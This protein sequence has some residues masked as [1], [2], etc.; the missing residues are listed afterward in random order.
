[1][2]DR[3]NR[4]RCCLVCGQIK[5]VQSFSSA[6]CEN[7]EEILQLR[8]SMDRILECTSAC[9]QGT[10][11]IIDSQASWL[12]KWQRS[13]G[14]VAGVYAVSVT[15]DLPEEIESIVADRGITPRC[16]Q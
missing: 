1:M 11:A 3:A 9:Y 12:A 6:G 16:S 14:C 2:K 4:S 15:G 10:V 5:S 7:C 13:R 8:G